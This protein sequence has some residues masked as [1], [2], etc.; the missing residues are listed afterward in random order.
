M[1]THSYNDRVLRA[2]EGMPVNAG[3]LVICCG[4][5]AATTSVPAGASVH[6]IW[7]DANGGDSTITFPNGQVLTV[8]NGS[9][10]SLDFHGLAGGGDY[11]IAGTTGHWL[12]SYVLAP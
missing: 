6:S 2:A 7:V 11:V 8:K 1:A 3:A 12:I 10:L 9:T 4:D 5:G